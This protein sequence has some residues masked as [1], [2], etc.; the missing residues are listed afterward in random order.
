MSERGAGV[1][2][3]Q[4]SVFITGVFRPSR[5]DG[6][7]GDVYIRCHCPSFLSLLGMLRL[8]AGYASVKHRDTHHLHPLSSLH[9][10]CCGNYERGVG[11]GVGGEGAF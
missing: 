1:E 10:V 5:G 2:L 4:R 9:S 3:D 6:C 8:T 7:L 11:V